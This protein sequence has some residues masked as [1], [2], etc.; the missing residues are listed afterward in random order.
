MHEFRADL[1]CHT[2]CS[3]GSDSPLALLHLAK[4]A[5]LQGLSITDHDS[6][7]AYTPEFF[8]EAANLGIEILPGIEISSE[9]D[10]S[11]VHILGYGFDLK[12]LE[13]KQFLVLMQKRRRNRNL[14]ILKKLAAKKISITEEELNAYATERTIGRPHIAA[15]M[16]KKGYVSS[17]KEAFDLFLREGASC[18][19]PGIRFSPKDVIDQIH[20]V[21]GKAVLAHP[22]FF[23]KGAFLTRLLSFAFDGIECYYARIVKEQEKPWVDLAKK[24][25]WIATGGSDYHGVIK[26]NIPLGA[27]WVGEATFRALQSREEKGSGGG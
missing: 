26:P 6:I 18:Y 27:S 7:E 11:A 8:S 13:L 14:E 3:D 17:V 21:G 9:M 20:R 12:N 16:V 10:D 5:G 2:T 24:K 25:G 1:H 15:L 22:H 23:K 4:E 19:T